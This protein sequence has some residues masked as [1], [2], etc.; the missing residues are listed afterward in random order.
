MVWYALLVLIWFPLRGCGQ[1]VVVKRVW[2]CLSVLTGLK[3]QVRTPSMQTNDERYNSSCFFNVN[4]NVR[5]CDLEKTSGVR[6]L[7]GSTSSLGE[8]KTTALPSFREISMPPIT[9]NFTLWI[10]GDSLIQQLMVSLACQLESKLEALVFPVHPSVNATPHH[11]CVKGIRGSGIGRMCFYYL[12]CFTG[13]CFYPFCPAVNM[14]ATCLED[15]YTLVGPNDTI[16]VGLGV[17]IREKEQTTLRAELSHYHTLRPS[18]L[19][20]TKHLFWLQTAAQH[21]STGTGRLE[22]GKQKYFLKKPCVPHR[23]NGEG[24]VNLATAETILDP[25]VP[26]YEVSAHAYDRH[27]GLRGKT[28]DCTHYCNPGVPDAWADLLGHYLVCGATARF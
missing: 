26:L 2:D 8:K 7:V 21:F 5:R 1:E 18:L 27:S 12:G 20:K 22:A 13:Q 15:L 6:V 9:E 16:F 11:Y 28:H 4:F 19:R 10:A 24:I 14:N 17:H 3:L 23:A 25:I